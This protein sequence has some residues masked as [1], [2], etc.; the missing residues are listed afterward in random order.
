[1]RNLTMLT[2][3]YQLTMMYGYYKKGMVKDKAVFD[4]FFRKGAGESEYAIVAGLSQVI[5]YLKNLHFGKE[6]VEYLR[7]LNLFSEDFLEFLG[8]LHFTGEIYAMPEGSVAFPYEPLVRVKA[9]IIEAQLIETALLN[10]VNH[11]T[12]IATKA[13]RVCMAANGGAVMEFGLRRAQGPDAGLYGA[14]AAVIGG[15]ASTSNVLAGQ[16]FG[17]KTAGTHAHSWV[18]SFDHEI[19]AFRAY[20]EIFPDSCLLLVDTYDVLRSGMPNAIK[21]FDGLRKQGH[22]PLGIRI[23]SGDLAY[24][25]KEC[26]KMLDIA[27]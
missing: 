24:L 2:D 5:D 6:D 10:I 12:L 1:M 14:R 8:G 22:E 18:M 15:C 16:Y 7:S 21:V 26:R 9:N 19:D 23:D 13:S 20:A 11:Q 27:G 25:S 3:L 17:L 4:V